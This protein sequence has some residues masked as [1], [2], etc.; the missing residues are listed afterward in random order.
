MATQTL[1]AYTQMRIRGAYRRPESPL[2]AMLIWLWGWEEMKESSGGFPCQKNS[3]DFFKNQPTP[4]KA[5]CRKRLLVRPP[6]RRTCGTPERSCALG[7]GAQGHKVAGSLGPWAL[8]RLG[9][10]LHP[11]Q[12]CRTS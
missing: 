1:A 9:A 3:W 6:G 8:G 4:M 5:K 11:M 12:A 7:A 10:I 2:R